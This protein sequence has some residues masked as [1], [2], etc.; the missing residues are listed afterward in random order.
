MIN[1]KP[2]EKYYLT[3]RIGQMDIIPLCCTRIFEGESFNKVAKEQRM[4]IVKS[5]GL[6]NISGYI[7]PA[8]IQWAFY[9]CEDKTF[10]MFLC[11]ENFNGK[12]V[13]EKSW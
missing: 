1:T 5:P 2:A 10:T 3:L 7:K 6:F 13:I 11:S 8:Q 4:K 12:T 9:T